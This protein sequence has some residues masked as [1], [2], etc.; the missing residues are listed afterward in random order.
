MLFGFVDQGFGGDKC[1]CHSL[2]SYATIH[3]PI[4]HVLIRNRKQ[5]VPILETNSMWL[6]D[7]L[8]DKVHV[9][10]RPQHAPWPSQV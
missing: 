8:N 3:Q 9:T 4:C 1:A 5:I 6:N 10:T 7:L 2:I